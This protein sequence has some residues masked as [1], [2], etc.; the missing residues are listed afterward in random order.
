[1]L[2]LAAGLR[3]RVDEMVKLNQPGLAGKVIDMLQTAA[4]LEV[5][6]KEGKPWEEDDTTEDEEILEDEKT[7]KDEEASKSKKDAK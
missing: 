3:S 7:K 5:L 1:M 4:Q 6:A 2:T